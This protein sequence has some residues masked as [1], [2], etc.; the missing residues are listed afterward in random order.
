MSRHFHDTPL[1]LN[2]F[3]SRI[4]QFLCKTSPKSNCQS[5]DITSH[6]S[7]SQTHTPLTAIACQPLCQENVHSLVHIFTSF[8][9]VRYRSCTIPPSHYSCACHRWVPCGWCPPP[10]RADRAFLETQTRPGQG[11]LLRPR[12]LRAWCAYLRRTSISHEEHRQARTRG[13]RLEACPPPVYLPL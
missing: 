11:F 4:T 12:P 1:K 8:R 2:T 7:I 6:S 9:L 3:L 13:R 5:L 10:R